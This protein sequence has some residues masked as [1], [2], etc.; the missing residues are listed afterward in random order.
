M[1]TPEPV[2]GVFFCADYQSRYCNP[3]IKRPTGD[4]P[5]IPWQEKPGRILGNPRRDPRMTSR[6]HSLVLHRRVRTPSQ[7]SL[8]CREIELRL[9]DDGRHLLLSRYVELYG[10]EQAAWCL[11]RHHRIPLNRMI[12]WMI[13]QGELVNG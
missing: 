1:K 13:G 5:E 4:N 11:V 8:H 10:D 3:A 9:A 7:D 6:N 12:R 2:S